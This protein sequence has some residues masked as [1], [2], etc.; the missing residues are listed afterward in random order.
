M[1]KLNSDICNIHSDN[2]SALS[3]ADLVDNMTLDDIRIKLNKLRRVYSKNLKKTKSNRGEFKGRLT[4]TKKAVTELGEGYFLCKV[5]SALHDVLHTFTNNILKIMLYLFKLCYFFII[6]LLFDFTFIH[7][8]TSLCNILYSLD[9]IKVN[10][11][12]KI[13]NN[14]NSSNTNKVSPIY[15]SYND[16]YLPLYIILGFILVVKIYIHLK[17]SI[18]NKK[19]QYVSEFDN[20]VGVNYKLTC[21]CNSQFCNICSQIPADLNTEKIKNAINLLSLKKDGLKK[22]R[23]TDNDSEFDKDVQDELLYM[24]TS[25]GSIKTPTW[26]QAKANLI[27]KIEQHLTKLK[28]KL[29]QSMDQDN[30]VARE[31]AQ[32]TVKSKSPFTSLL[33]NINEN[34][35]KRKVSEGNSETEVQNTRKSL[36]KLSIKPTEHEN[37]EDIASHGNK[38]LFKKFDP[39]VKYVDDDSFYDTSEKNNNNEKRAKLTAQKLVKEHDK[40]NKLDFPAPNANKQSLSLAN[41]MSLYGDLD[42]ELNLYENNQLNS[43][44]ELVMSN[45]ANSKFDQMNISQEQIVDDSVSPQL[46]NQ[47]ALKHDTELKTLKKVFDDKIVDLNKK[48]ASETNNENINK[49]SLD[50][51]NVEVAYKKELEGIQK[52]HQNEIDSSRKQSDSSPKVVNEKANK[53]GTTSGIHGRQLKTTPPTVS[54]KNQ[55]SV[56]EKLL[57]SDPGVKRDAVRNDEL[58]KNYPRNDLTVLLYGKKISDYMGDHY[59]MIDEVKRCLKKISEPSYVELEVCNVT[60]R[61]CI[62]IVTDNYDDYL[63][64]LNAPWPKDAFGSGVI[65]KP[66]LLNQ[67]LIIDCPVRDGEEDPLDNPATIKH[68]QSLGLFAPV[69]LNPGDSRIKVHPNNLNSLLFH[70][71]KESIQLG[72]KMRR[73]KPKIKICF[74]CSICGIIGNHINCDRNRV[75]LICNCNDLDHAFNKCGNQ[76]NCKNC[77]QSHPA[78]SDSC[79]SL[80]KRIVAEND[81]LA[82]L[83][84]GEGILARKVEVL[85]W[86]KSNVFIE[87]ATGNNIDMRAVKQLIRDE[88]GPL[89]GELDEFRTTLDKHEIKIKELTSNVLEIKSDVKNTKESVNNLQNEVKSNHEEYKSNQISLNNKIDKFNTQNLVNMEEIIK[90]YMLPQAATAQSASSNP[91]S[92]ATP[93]TSNGTA[94]VSGLQN[95][96]H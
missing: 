94:S 37:K 11:N 7:Y 40:L 18:R 88:M 74:V 91:H 20:K 16:Q 86:Y 87:P 26:A 44:I 54:H 82:S 25:Q 5:N 23:K 28:L 47:I 21:K 59:S 61:P 69:R 48:I 49:L 19:Y 93:H 56:F 79:E 62:K 39:N 38:G 32:G 96:Q 65:A 95:G 15:L 35:K 51:K 10:L 63:E 33:D 4:L 85:K 6:Y 2:L 78:N 55:K 80:K 29:V 36:E 17:A 41:Y 66:G 72:K 43:T 1:N 58:E 14:R 64:M 30:K 68:L 76:A 77:G 12:L 67:A 84:V 42:D 45:E 75:C 60:N 71:I 57:N 24:K 70:I 50:L 92:S 27:L 9:N 34:N 13:I 89:R 22:I 8:I 90:K 81:Y 46:T 3:N 83:C 52:I 73:I 53:H 31:K